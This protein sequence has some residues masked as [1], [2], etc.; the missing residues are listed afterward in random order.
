VNNY[1][2]KNKKEG[3]M[4]SITITK[5]LDGGKKIPNKICQ[6]LVGCNVSL[7][8]PPSMVF[9]GNP[10]FR[11]G[12]SLLGWD[13]DMFNSFSV[14]HGATC[15]ALMVMGED[16]AKRFFEAKFDKGATFFI[17]NRNCRYNP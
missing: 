16:E 10:I 8:S 14:S 3:I 9:L 5:K 1:L 6:A 2:F 15:H 13:G 4:S 11:N 17:Y 7:C 12:K